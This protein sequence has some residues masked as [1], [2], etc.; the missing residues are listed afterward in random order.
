MIVPNQHRH[1]T[2]AL[3]AFAVRMAASASLPVEQ[4]RLTPLRRQ[5]RPPKIPPRQNRPAPLR[6]PQYT[7]AMSTT[8][9]RD[10][11]LTPGAR[12]LAGLLV[13]L[14]GREG[15]ADLTRGFLA[16]Q[17]GVSS[18]TVARQLAELRRYCYVVT[19]HLI[20][21]LGQTTGL[22]VGLLDPLLPFW[23]AAG[24]GVT[25]APA[26]ESKILREEAGKPVPARPPVLGHPRYRKPR[27][28]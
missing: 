7:G 18:R 25:G 4:L 19:T 11:R 15:Y 27:S 28:P 10:Q 5:P 12:V 1:L 2:G 24:E 16:A 22:R 23:E 3:S 9:L 20:G 13:A 6:S 14:A 8:V 21:D 26:L 17:L